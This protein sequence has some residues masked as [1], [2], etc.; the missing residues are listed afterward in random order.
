MKVLDATMAVLPLQTTPTTSPL[1]MLVWHSHLARICLPTTFLQT[2]QP[3]ILVVS[4]LPKSSNHFSLIPEMRT[5]TLC[6]HMDMNVY[7]ITGI[8]ERMMMHGRSLTS[9]SPPLNSAPLTH[10]I[11]QLAATLEQRTHSLASIL[12]I[13]LE[14]SSIQ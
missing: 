3:N 9:V 13:L 7:R 12:G 5:T 6:S 1:P 2:T 11:A 8:V 4:S 14:D 10:P